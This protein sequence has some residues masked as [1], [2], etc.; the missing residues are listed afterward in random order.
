MKQ[1]NI[2]FAEKRNALTF[3][4]KLKR[5]VIYTITYIAYVEQLSEYI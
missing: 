1:K 4:Y 3:Q 5:M 2:V